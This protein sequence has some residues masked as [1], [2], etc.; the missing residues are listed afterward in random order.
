M[1]LAIHGLVLLHRRRIT[2]IPFLAVAAVIT[3]TAA[4]TFGITRYRAPVDALLPVLAAGAIVYRLDR[5][6]PPLERAGAPLLE[7][8]AEPDDTDETPEPATLAT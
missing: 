8:S 6:R 3:I 5:S 4:S 1:P 2:I 7:P